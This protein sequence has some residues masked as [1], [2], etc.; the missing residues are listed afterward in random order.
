MNPDEAELLAYWFGPQV[1]A[2]GAY[3]AADVERWFGDG[4]KRDDEIRQ[5]FGELHAEAI[6]GVL[7]GWV[8]S[9]SGRLGLILLFDQLSRHLYRETPTAFSF[10]A[11][12]QAL[13]LD[14]L[15]RGDDLRLAPIE[16]VF[17][18]LPLEHAEDLELQERSV[19]LFTALHDSLAPEIQPAY[20][21]FV[22][23]AVRHRD[24]I[25]RFGRFPDLNAILARP[26][27]D[28]E[29]AF[30]KEPGSSFL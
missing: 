30:L 5:R 6:G 10:D 13:V 7:D 4:R 20:A 12:A 29:T 26:S 2:D 1:E 25:A 8:E 11:R 3:P 19:T 15:A 27:T 17:F 28:E 16:R 22:D 21:G 14:G 9:P 18:Y 23:Y 24:V